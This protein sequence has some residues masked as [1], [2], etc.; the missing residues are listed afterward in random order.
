M[1]FKEEGE[2]GWLSQECVALDLGVQ[3][4]PYVVCRDYFKIFFKNKNEEEEEDDDD[5]DSPWSMSAEI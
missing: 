1:W 4:E 3:F 5:D 2:L